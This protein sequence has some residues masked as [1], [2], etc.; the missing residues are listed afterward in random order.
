VAWIGF[1]RD[2]VADLDDLAP[3]ACFSTPEVRTIFERYLAEWDE[4]AHA[5]EKFLWERDI[6]AEQVEYHV[7]AFHQ[8]AS[9][10]AQYEERTGERQSPQEGD[11]FYL[12]LI[13]GVLTAL[14]AEGPSSAAFAKHLGEF[15]PG[16]D[17]S[18]L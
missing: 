10:L 16:R 15:W 14:E 3:G 18:L 12:A 2:V 9:M 5:G 7:H 11:E 6:P 13:H 1:A 8:A 4:A 17:L